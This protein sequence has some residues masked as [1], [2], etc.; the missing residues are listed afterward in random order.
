MSRLRELRRAKL[1]SQKELGDRVGVWYQTVQGWESGARRPRTAAMRKLCEVL[2]ITPAE[3][4]AVL[5]ADAE[6]WA[7]KAAA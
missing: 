2:E 1:L 6:E 5:D 4:L 7:E 3:L